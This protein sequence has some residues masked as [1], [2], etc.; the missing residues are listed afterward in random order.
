MVLLFKGILIIIFLKILSDLFSLPTIGYLL[1]YIIE[2]GPL[3]LIV[4]FQPELRRFLGFL[5][6]V[7][8]ISKL[9]SSNNSSQSKKEID[10]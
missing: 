9:F 5:G 4:I 3:A 2:W 8:I 1:D 10:V 6:Q 7:D